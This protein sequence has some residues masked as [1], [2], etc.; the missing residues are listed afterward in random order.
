MPI[1]SPEVYAQMLDRAKAGKFA[2]PAINTSSSQTINAAIRGF[3]E[4]ES[5]GIVQVSWGGAESVLH[6]LVPLFV[7]AR[8]LQFSWRHALSSGVLG[9]GLETEEG[10]GNVSMS[11]ERLHAFILDLLR[12][13]GSCK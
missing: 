12:W 7:E 11:C 8:G 4:A 13:R 3:A 5:D 10:S 6:R 2:Y 9:G 1:A